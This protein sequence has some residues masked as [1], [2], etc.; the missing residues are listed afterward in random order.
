METNMEGIYDT[1][2]QRYSTTSCFYYQFLYMHSLCIIVNYL[3]GNNY[4][5]ITMPTRSHK[6]YN[7]YPLESLCGSLL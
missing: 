4:C 5:E 1:H 6:L 3:Y 2:K 7:T